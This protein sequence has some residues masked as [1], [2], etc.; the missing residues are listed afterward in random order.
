MIGFNAG[1]ITIENNITANVEEKIVFLSPSPIKEKRTVASIID[2]VRIGSNKVT[3]VTI[4]SAIPYSEVVN[5]P[6]YR[7]T[8]K[9]EMNLDKKLETANNTAFSAKYL[10]LFLLITATPSNR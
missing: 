4:K 1:H 3:V 9:K 8:I 2:K 6:V 5:T 10:Y 7:G